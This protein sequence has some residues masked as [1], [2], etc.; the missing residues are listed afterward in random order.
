[1]QMVDP[2]LLGRYPAKGLHQA[3][4]VAGKCVE[5]HPS[6]RPPIADVATVLD[7]LASLL[8]EGEEGDDIKP[9]HVCL[10]LGV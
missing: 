7:R 5:E 8:E 4:A 9:H 3:L 10:N 1:M 2:V 6:M